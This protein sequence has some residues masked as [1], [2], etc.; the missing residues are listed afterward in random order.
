[1]YQNLG[2]ARRYRI[3]LVCFG[4]T[5]LLLVCAAAAQDSRGHILGRV[6]DK[7]SALVA[8][9]E[10]T[11][12]QVEMNTRVAARSNNDG[13]YDLPFLLPGIYRIEVKAPGFK[14]YARHPIE[15]RVGDTVTL[16]IQLEVGNVTEK[17]DVSAEAAL[18]ES[19]TASIS[20][21][22][23]NKQVTDLPLGGGDV[24]FLASLTAGV[25][26][27][28]AP[29]HNWL[30]SAT[31]VMSNLNVAGTPNG[32]N[33]FM[34]DGISNMTRGWVSFSPPADMI[35]EFRVQTAGY[36]ASQGHAAG[37]N[38]SMSLKSGTNTLHGTVNWQ[39]APNPWQANDFFTNKQIYDL[40][41]GPVTDAKI[42]SLAP[43]RKVNRYSATLGGPVVL[44]RLYRG[45]NR[46]FWMYGFQGFDRRNPT[47]G[48]YTVPTAA[49]GRGD[50]SALLKL[51][52]TYQLYDPGTITPTS[53]GHYTRQALPGNVIPANRISPLAANYLKLFPQANLAGQVDGRQ[54]Y[55][56]AARDNND[57]RQ[58][59]ARIDHDFSERHRMFGRFTQ[60]WLHYYHGNQFANESHG[61][62]RHRK[63]WGGGLD[64]VYT[65]SPSLILNVKYG[66]TR[67]LQSDFP[68]STGYDLT[69]LGLPQSLAGRIDP[70]GVAFPVVTFDGFTQLGETGGTRFITNYHNWAGGFTKVAGDH[71]VRWG[72][73]FRLL[74]ENSV[75]YGNAAPAMAFNNTWTKGPTDT[76]A[77]API[78]QDLASLMLGLPTGGGIDLNASYSE[79]STFGAL[80]VQDDWKPTRRLTVNLGLRWEAEGAPTERFNRAARG[81]DTSV[82]SPISAQALAAYSKSPDAALPVSQFRT[83]GVLTFAAVDGQPRS[84]FATPKR[85]FAPRAGLAFRVNPKTVLRA[86]YGWF[87]DTN[88]INANHA[89]QEGF[90]QRTNLTP[91]QD[92]GVTFTGTL[93]NP[94]PDGLIQPSPVGPNTYIGRSITFNPDTMPTAYMQRWSFSVQRELPGRAVLEVGYLGNRGTHIGTTRQIDSTPAQYLSRSPFRDQ[95]TINYLGAALPNPF[96]GIPQ[97]AGGGITGTTISRG[98]LLRPF[99]QYNGITFTDANGISWFHSASVRVEKRF[100]R[101]LTMNVNWSWSKYMEAVEYLNATDFEPSHVISASDRPRRL[102]IS[103]VWQ[104]PV[105]RG[106]LLLAHA[107]NAIN[108]AVGGWQYQA[109]W[110]L[111][112]GAPTGFGNVLFIG[113][114]HSIPLPADQ[115]KV[116]QWFNINAGFNRLAADALASNIRTFPL[117]L[118]GVRNPG[119]DYWNMSVSKQFQFKER[120]KLQVR[121]DWEG[122]L[123]SPQFAAPNAA[124]TNT[125]FGQISATTPEARRVFVGAK[126]M[127]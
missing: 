20:T 29:G 112:S 47:N 26:T 81:F 111:Q 35:S 46:T 82:P 51:G 9:A 119:Q 67:F 15:V 99:P 117:R 12:T 102:T 90:S 13:N 96:F 85:N 49:E 74:R 77:G 31:D 18:V 125:V 110:I 72:G 57:F 78:G 79:Q 19:S 120:M 73:E 127:F 3:P 45:K 4:S 98:N 70:Q 75:N 84:Y 115:R 62:D 56:V 103:G 101:G 95:A 17:I 7:S 63:Q 124:P 105:G 123:N 48:Y 106:H 66:F 107:P 10:V 60:S 28:Q 53:G 39:V 37:G 83:T 40:S 113:D 33:E 104:L 94:F 61:I 121:T 21:V 1:M 97:F 6:L 5:L 122:A 118:N 88:G 114:V 68:F 2:M 41:T 76:S 89:N 108:A 43:P 55:Q 24:M 71:S 25:T 65:F 32:S 36:D 16:D 86:G 80:Y 34:L 93:A 14:H 59:L 44:P 11:A 27:A 42:K 69:R 91:S 52:N 8:G 64:D 126:V 54:N 30:P 116:E 109:I 100:S 87:F 38:I 92:N 58:N 23:G 50:F 22:V